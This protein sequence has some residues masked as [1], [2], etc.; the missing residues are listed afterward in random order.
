MPTQKVSDDKKIIEN[1]FYL[2]IIDYEL[3]VKIW[4]SK[5][6]SYTIKQCFTNNLAMH[7]IYAKMSSDKF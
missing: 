1:N 3:S 4:L 5:N 6:A 7:V 2:L